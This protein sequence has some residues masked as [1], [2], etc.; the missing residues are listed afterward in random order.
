MSL[1]IEL[2]TTPLVTMEQETADMKSNNNS[3]IMKNVKSGIVA[4]LGYLDGRFYF[5]R[6]TSLDTSRSLP[7][8]APWGFDSPAPHH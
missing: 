4:L 3:N 7:R 1:G 2:S 5:E 6:D 8:S